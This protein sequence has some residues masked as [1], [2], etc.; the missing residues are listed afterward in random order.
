MKRYRQANLRKSTKRAGS[1][2][3]GSAGFRATAA[4]AVAISVIR[5]VENSGRRADLVLKQSL[6]EAR[7]PKA[8]ARLCAETVFAWYRWRW[9]IG[10]RDIDERTIRRAAS[11]AKRFCENPGSF[12]PEELK[13]RAVPAWAKDHFNVS[14]EFIRSLQAEPTLWLRARPRG[15]SELE[16]MLG[17]ARAGVVPGIADALRYEGEEDLFRTREFSEGRFEIQDIGSQA[18]GLV[19]A[20][21][22]RSSWWDACAGEGGKTLHLADLLENKGVVWASDRSKRR[23]DSLRRRGARAKLFNTRI[24]MWDGSEKRP[25]KTKF[26]GVLVDAPCSGVG[27]WGRNP[28]AR[29]TTSPDDISELAAIQ[30]QLLANAAPAVKPGGRLVFAV[31]TLTRAETSEV[32]D[33]FSENQ[34]GFEPAPFLDPFNPDGSPRQRVTWWPQDTGGNGMF[35]A[36]WRRVS[37]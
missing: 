9:F 36:A 10:S 16:V 29:W 13:A 33:W 23:L 1:P 7:L 35:V 11:L 17:K 4:E 8:D 28:H 21:G 20:P 31:C 6:R 24:A 30:K 32:A 37:H 22:E 3:R 5:T 34:H 2:R 15:A 26:D 27:T 19:C 25:T 12:D 14:P 18:V